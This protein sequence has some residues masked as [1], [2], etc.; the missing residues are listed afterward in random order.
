[1]YSESVTYIQG[2]SLIYLSIE[3]MGTIAPTFIFVEKSKYFEKNDFRC[4]VINCG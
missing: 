2:H 3:L 1:M 4:Y